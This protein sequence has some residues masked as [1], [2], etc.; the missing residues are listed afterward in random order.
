MLAPRVGLFSLFGFLLMLVLNTT[1]EVGSVFCLSLMK[2]AIPLSSASI[3]S[4]FGSFKLVLVYTHW[5]YELGNPVRMAEMIAGS[6]IPF[7]C[8]ALLILLERVLILFKY[9]I[10]SPFSVSLVLFN[11]RLRFAV[12]S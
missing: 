12:L 8:S 3:S 4:S 2:F 5:S 6:V 1:F 10:I 9:S 7:S 11:S